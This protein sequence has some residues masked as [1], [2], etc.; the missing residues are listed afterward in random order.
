MKFIDNKK[1]CKE[2]K[3]AM[4]FISNDETVRSKTVQ[5]FNDF[6]SR[7]LTTQIEKRRT[8][9]FFDAYHKKLLI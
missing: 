6:N 3:L 7:S 9:S 4:R 2:M 8:I 1:Y 5:D